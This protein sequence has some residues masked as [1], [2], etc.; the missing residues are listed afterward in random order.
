MNK[1]YDEIVSCKETGKIMS[2]KSEYDDT[3]PQRKI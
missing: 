2:G 1:F 3:K